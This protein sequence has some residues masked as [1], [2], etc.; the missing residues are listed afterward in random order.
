MKMKKFWAGGGEVR[1][2]SRSWFEESYWPKPQ[3]LRVE[4]PDYVSTVLKVRLIQ[5]LP[6]SGYSTTASGVKHPAFTYPRFFRVST[7]LWFP[8]E[9]I[10]TGLWIFHHGLGGEA[11]SLHVSTLLKGEDRTAVPDH[12]PLLHHLQDTR[13]RRHFCIFL[14]LLGIVSS[15]NT[16]FKPRI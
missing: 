9:R 10:L 1:H 14:S 11:P 15:A 2:C 6:A 8:I 4:H 13:L 7:T 16:T 12:R 3:T 5:T